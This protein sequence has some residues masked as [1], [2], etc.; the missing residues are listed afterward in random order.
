[1]A[2]LPL[3]PGEAWT[4]EACGRKVPGRIAQCRC[5]APAP[6]PALALGDDDDA[7]VE[8]PAP[9]AGPRLLWWWAVPGLLGLGMLA[10]LYLARPEPAAPA[11][12]TSPLEAV[13]SD[14]APPAD[15]TPVTVDDEE[16]I[17]ES[18]VTD[19]E[20]IALPPSSEPPLATA[21]V[22][23]LVAAALDGVVTV[24]AGQSRGTGFFAAPDLVVT[25]A[26]VMGQQ[27]DARLRLDDGSEATA[28]V[29]RLSRELDLAILRTSVRRP[30]AVL[31]LGSARTLRAGQEVIVIGSPL[32]L[33]S[34]VTRGIV[35]AL[36]DASGVLLVQTD[37]AINPGNSGGPLLDRQGRVVG[38]AT[39]KQ[40]EA[41]SLGFA[42]AADHARDLLENRRSEPAAPGL[43]AVR[44]MTM[45]DGASPAE[46]ERERGTRA[47]EAAV[48][49]I[50]ARADQVD[51][52]WTRY[53]TSCGATAPPAAGDREWMAIV[54]RAPT[55]TVQAPGCVTYFNDVRAMA[56]NV[57]AVLRETEESARR[58]G[59][60]PGVQ[61]DTLRAHRLTWTP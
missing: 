28:R 54:D 42:V 21:S 59:V 53:K 46:V 27:L 37:A 45:P 6:S 33:Q 1:M 34:T 2:D 3:G 10:G 29:D 5:G 55:T 36:R 8:A 11:A 58:A 44:P 35:S 39:L 41:E 19:T 17:P 50:A 20:A 52:Y 40:G 26:H 4:C 12:V 23:D 32:G 7:A 38:V 24:I 14:T 61:R 22:E 56:T 49:A 15:A 18:A 48:K 43:T 57:R 51:E 47:F 13:V 25:N 31:P 60:Y 9:P 30:D 16:V